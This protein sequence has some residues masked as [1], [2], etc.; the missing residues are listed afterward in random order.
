MGELNPAG[1]SGE[2]SSLD[3]DLREGLE[4]SWLLQK[5]Y[6]RI[7]RLPNPT[8]DA[9][10]TGRALARLGRTLRLGSNGPTFHVMSRISTSVKSS[11]RS[12]F[13]E[14]LIQAG[15]AGQIIDFVLGEL[16]LEAI[17]LVREFDFES[18]AALGANDVGQF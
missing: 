14:P 11:L 4:G 10:L 12:E 2:Y 7:W 18:F 3:Q 15:Q 5:V 9:S 1:P 6:R 8:L 13:R 16:C 17:R